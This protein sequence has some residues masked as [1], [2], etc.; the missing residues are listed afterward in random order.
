M[1][2]ISQ[3]YVEDDSP[4]I[5]YFPFVDTSL[6]PNASAGWEQ[7]YS[8]SGGASSPGQVGLGYSMHYTN[9]NQAS[10]MIKWNGEL[11]TALTNH[12]IK[13]INAVAHRFPR[14][15]Y[16]SSG[17]YLRCFLSNNIGRN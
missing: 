11:S 12:I 3:F 14:H 7:F 10:F 2:N 4:E 9:L 8:G 15:W 5:V 1:A 6:S 13:T 17:E 16:R